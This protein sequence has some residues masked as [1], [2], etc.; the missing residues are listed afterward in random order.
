M[1]DR[2]LQVF[3]AVAKHGSF[4][5]AAEHLHMTQPAVTFQIKQLEEHF[6]TRLLDRGHGKITLTTAGELVLAYA[7]RILGLSAELDSRVS[8]LTDELA[9]Q[10]KIGTSTT[11]AAYWLP[12]ILEGFKRRYPRVLPRVLVGTSKL[13]EDRV[14]A[15]ELDIGLIE[16]ATEQHAIERHSAARD[17]LLVI[18]RPDHPL[19][20]FERLSA[21]DLVGYPFIDRDPGNGIRQIADEFF[22]TAGIAGSEI[23]L[24]A[25]LGSLAAIKQLAAAGLGFAIASRRAIRRDVEEGRL[26]AVPLEPRTYTPLEVIVPRDKFRS[27]LITAFADYACEQ[28]A[29]IAEQEEREQ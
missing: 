29:L 6:D 12:Q 20:R 5:R 7:E 24:C 21:K 16:I 9:G 3:H 13:T 4:T 23:T 14:A 2:R 11:I 18:C 26:A 28:F 15:R 27:R 25:E 8:E 1:A 19:A 22:E 17:E 10:I